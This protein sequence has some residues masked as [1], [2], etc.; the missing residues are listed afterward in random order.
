MEEIKKKI[1][2]LYRELMGYLSQAPT[3]KE[4]A[5]LY[6]TEFQHYNKTIQYLNSITGNDYSRFTVHPLQGN[7]YISTVT[8]RANLGG[9]IDNLY[10]DYF[11]D[12]NAPFSSSPGTIINQHQS[13]QQS[14]SVLLLDVQKKITTKLATTTDEKERNFLQKFENMLPTITNTAHL[15]KTAM[16]LCSQMGIDPKNVGTL[17]S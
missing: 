12:E 15:I 3:H 14:I 7:T 6:S 2:P 16:D 17:F 11:S 8:Y 4:K 5:I 10:G 1:R 13:Q 9:L